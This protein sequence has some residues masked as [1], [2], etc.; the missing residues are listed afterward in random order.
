GQRGLPP[1]LRGG[2]PTQQGADRG[3]GQA[4][5]RHLAGGDD[6]AA[7]DE[8]AGRRPG[9]EVR[10]RGGAG[11]FPRGAG[12]GLEAG[13]G[14]PAMEPEGAAQIADGAGRAH[15]E[16]TAM[17]TD[18]V[19]RRALDRLL[20]DD[21]TVHEHPELLQSF[22]AY[23]TPDGHRARLDLTQADRIFSH[24][25]MNQVLTL[26]RRLKDFLGEYDGIHVTARV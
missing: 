6:R 15:G 26:R 25:A 8:E 5:R 21:R 19:G 22:A 3:R 1:A 13:L 11:P 23:I 9:A 10:P 7:A 17:L 14:R 18:P 4:P 12:L 24:D 20:I 2:R 16:V